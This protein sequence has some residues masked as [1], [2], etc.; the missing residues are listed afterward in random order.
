MEVLKESK[1][2]DN[3]INNLIQQL[4]KEI[5]EKIT[6][7]EKV[8]EE[9]QTSDIQ[10]IKNK[11]KK[12]VQN[13]FDLILEKILNYYLDKIKGL[14]IKEYFEITKGCYSNDE[15]EK[16]PKNYKKAS[17]LIDN[18]MEYCDPCEKYG[19]VYE[20]A[21][22]IAYHIMRKVVGVNEFAIILPLKIDYIKN[23]SIST[24]TLS[25]ELDSE[26]WYIIL[27][28]ATHYY[29]LSKIK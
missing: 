28:I 3:D 8:D 16:V 17:R 9:L 14:N 29:V 1:L 11:T 10:K 27:Y 4:E 23:Y 24:N 7:L 19:N 6:N 26:I 5:V 20:D 12:E 21:E 25:N 18:I 2:L 15:W 13:Y 22:Y